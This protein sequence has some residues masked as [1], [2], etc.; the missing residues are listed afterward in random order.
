L[1]CPSQRIHLS[2]EDGILA[3]L[4]E[5]RE[6][7]WMTLDEIEDVDVFPLERLFQLAQRYVLGV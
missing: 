5:R 6:R 3:E 4:E 1:L 7:V 2:T